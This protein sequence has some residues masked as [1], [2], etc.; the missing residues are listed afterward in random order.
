MN[1]KGKTG[2]RVGVIGK[3]KAIACHC[4]VLAERG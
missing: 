4:V 3:E 1:I 2:E